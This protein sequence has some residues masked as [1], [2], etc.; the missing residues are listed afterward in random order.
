MK[1]QC[2]DMQEYIFREH[3]GA[4]V[5]AS[6]IAEASGVLSG[7]ALVL[8]RAEELR[9]SVRSDWNDGDR[10][11][12]GAELIRV[13]GLPVAVIR[14]EEWII[15]AL[16]KACGIATT[17][18]HVLEMAGTDLRVVSGGA[19]KMPWEIRNLVRQAVCNGGLEVRMLPR[20]F[21]YLD[22]NYVRILGGIGPA[23]RAVS[24]LGCPVVIQV[25]GEL[26]TLEEEALEA[27]NRGAAVVMV[28]TGNREDLRRVNRILNEHGLRDRIK[29]AFA[30]CI[31]PDDLPEL[32]KEE[33]DI[34]DIGYAILDA[35][36]IPMRF[37]VLGHLPSGRS[38]R[39][40][41]AEK[42]EKRSSKINVSYRD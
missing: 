37:D 29:L 42:T 17:A 12:P 18:R 1:P 30:G 16:S 38:H 26:A 3:F 6:L 23:L 11:A 10:F 36:C 19:K 27:A 31:K 40:G 20:E 9:L 4:N 34:L 8:A 41:T 2:N 5:H 24:E 7:M 21:V 13:E 32:K 35:P 25:R 14:S 39:I 28:D 33:V 22:K 15:G